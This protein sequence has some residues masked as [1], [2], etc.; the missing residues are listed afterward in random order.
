M[1]CADCDNA[2]AARRA[3]QV[4]MALAQMPQ[5][6][7][8]GRPVTVSFGVTEIQPGD[9]AETMLRRADRALADGQGQGPQHRRATRHRR[10]RQQPTKSHAPAGPTLPPARATAGTNPRH[11]RPVA[12]GD[13]E[14]PRLRR[15]PPRPRSSRSTATRCN[16]K[17]PRKP[18]AGFRRLTDRPVSFQL[19]LRF[20]EQRLRKQESEYVG[21]LIRTKIY[22][23]INPRK[24]RDRRRGDV[25]HRARQM[26]TSFRAYLM[27]TA[28]EESGEPPRGTW[29]RAKRILAPWLAWKK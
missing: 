16:W 11:A 2:A 6:K 3:E 5:P 8:N 9:T 15:R 20:E 26:F 25:G 18:R 29:V 14:A 12:D 23:S 21:H 10:R 22:V 27:A 7:M 13:R 1:L 4:R 28:D 19:D 17:S 24:D